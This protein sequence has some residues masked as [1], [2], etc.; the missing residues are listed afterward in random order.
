[1][2]KLENCGSGICENLYCEN[3]IKKLENYII[4]YDGEGIRYDIS[5]N[6]MNIIQEGVKIFEVDFSPGDIRIYNIPLSI[7][8]GKITIMLEDELLY[9]IFR[10]II[11]LFDLNINDY[12]YI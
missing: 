9:E 12:D 5:E 11:K 6:E 2:K 1:M 8:A 7:S 4:D 10:Y 3:K